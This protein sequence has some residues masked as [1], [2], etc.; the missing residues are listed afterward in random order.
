MRFVQQLFVKRGVKRHLAQVHQMGMRCVP[1]M[2][3]P[4][5]LLR[6]RFFASLTSRSE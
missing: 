2:G 6:N 1:M 3:A 5:M 4:P